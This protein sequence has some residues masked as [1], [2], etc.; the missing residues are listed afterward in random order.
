[1]IH[2]EIHKSQDKHET[3]LA[4]QRLRQGVWVLSLVRELRSY[5]P[6]CQK[7]TEAVL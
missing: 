7:T 3:S 1:M 5:K 4:V 2:K 6:G